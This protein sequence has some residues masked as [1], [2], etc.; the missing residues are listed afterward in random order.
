MHRG[1]RDILL[2]YGISVMNLYRSQLA[3]MLNEALCVHEGTFVKMGWE[4]NFVHDYM[5]EMAHS[6]IMS[7][8]GN[9]GD[10]V[11]VVVAIVE[12]SHRE[13]GK[14]MQGINR[15]A[16]QFWRNSKVSDG[17]KASFNPDMVIA[18][19]KFFVLE[20]SQELDYQLYHQLPTEIYVA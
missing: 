4:E 10:L 16:T 7:A 12:A 3:M 1:L 6:S 19:I 14:K 5:G 17:T 9:S 20:W 18:L 15:D 13:D 8:G 2:A 11:R